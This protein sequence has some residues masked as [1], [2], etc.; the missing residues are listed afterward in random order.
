MAKINNMKT[1][2]IQGMSISNDKSAK[3]TATLDIDEPTY[4]EIT[5]YGPLAQRKSANRISVTQWVIPGKHIIEGDAMMLELP[6]LV[7]DVQSPP[8][9]IKL[10]GLP[11]EVKIEANIAML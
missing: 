6:G 4:I 9:H 10:E 3:F 1:P 11:Q 2:I 5:A 7:V 8:T